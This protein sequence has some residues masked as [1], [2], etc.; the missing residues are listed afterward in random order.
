MKS[1]SREA[2]SMERTKA[3]IIEVA[4]AARVSPS[5]VSRV[6]NGT[7]HVDAAKAERV[8]A[9]VA[10]LGYVPNAFARSLL[11][12]AGRW[13]GVLVPQLADEFYGRV[14]TGIEDALKRGGYQ[15]V[16]SLG[17][18]ERRTEVESIA[19]FL[20]ARMAGLVLVSDHLP[21]RDVVAL[22]RAR[23]PIVLVNRVI[24]ELAAHAIR[25]DN[26]YSGAL[27]TRHLL[28]CG[29]TRIAHVT[30]SL[31]R[32]GA[33]ERLE[34]YHQA[35]RD[36]GIARDDR[37]VFKGD[38]TEDSG[39]DA[40]VRALGSTEFTAVFAANDRMAAGAIAAIRDAGLRVPTDISVVG[41]DN[42][43]ISRFTCPALTTV[44]YPVTS[45][46]R[47]AAEHLLQLIAGADPPPLPL[48]QP[49]LVE[50]DSTC[51][52]VK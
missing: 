31:H 15:M 42:T 32:T 51:A 21:E 13:V 9:A 48:I 29:H 5:T 28:E 17:H 33:R 24:P 52:P 36:H 22:S 40:M 46:G 44:D 25:I 27:A 4:R 39:R 3:T 14:V 10:R 35:L 8:H 37:L 6:L 47:Q 19:M 16:C 12:H 45:M 26:V 2:R 38:F 23:H 20:E 30:G 41:F 50:R 43:A 49:R 1:V 34:G 7:A 18:G 11:G